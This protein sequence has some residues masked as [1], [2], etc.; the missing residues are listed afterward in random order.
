LAECL[1]SHAA[2]H[3]FFIG[4]TVMTNILKLQTL[5]PELT[6]NFHNGLMSTL[7]SICPMAS[8]EDNRKSFE[9]E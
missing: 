4:E 8:G 5:K 6:T 7:S 9:R 1:Q 3:N 2:I